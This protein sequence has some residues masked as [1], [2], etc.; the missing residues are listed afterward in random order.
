MKWWRILISQ[1]EVEASHEDNTKFSII[2]P[3]GSWKVVVSS[4]S[5]SDMNVSGES[6]KASITSDDMIRAGGCRT[7]DNIGCFLLVTLPND[8]EASL[9]NVQDYDDT[10]EKTGKPGLGWTEV[11]N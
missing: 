4:G 10:R 11:I 8:T 9:P 5:A 6:V 3:R 7:R 1:S 2:D